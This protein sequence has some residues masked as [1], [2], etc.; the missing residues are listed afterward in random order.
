MVLGPSVRLLLS[1]YAINPNEVMSTGP[2]KVLLKS[3]VLKHLESGIN[4][5]SS[6][7]K[8]KLEGKRGEI[9]FVVDEIT[10]RSI[11]NTKPISEEEIET[12]N[13]GGF[14]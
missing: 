7:F 9:T 10:A 4:S 3:D 8:Q 1:R 5:K 6:T 2:H 12:I 13:G 14:A 11:Y